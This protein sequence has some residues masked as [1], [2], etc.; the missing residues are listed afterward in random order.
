[1]HSVIFLIV[2]KKML[3]FAFKLK[4]E[5]FGVLFRRLPPPPLP[6][7]LSTNGSLSGWSAGRLGPA[8]QAGLGLVRLGFAVG[9]TWLREFGLDK[10]GVGWAGLGCVMLGWGG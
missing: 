10:D 5:P 1:M 3:A 2:C 7:A 8:L 6:K 4:F 9:R